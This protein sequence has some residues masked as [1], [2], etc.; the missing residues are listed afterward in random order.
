MG[1][2]ISTSDAYLESGKLAENQGD[3]FVPCMICKKELE[4]EEED[5]F[6]IV[7][8]LVTATTAK[9]ICGVNRAPIIFLLLVIDFALLSFIFY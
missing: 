2:D 1:D 3:C 7:A 5:A 9:I 4:S 8:I 6:T